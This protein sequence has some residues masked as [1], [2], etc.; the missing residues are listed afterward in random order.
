MDLEV[1]REK[2][3]LDNIFALAQKLPY[4][5]EILSH[6]AKYLC[7]LVSGFIEN[8]FR[9]M[10]INYISNKS[11]KNVAK[12]ATKYIEGI[13]NLNEPKIRDLL[14]KFNNDWCIFLEENISTEEKDAFDT[15]VINRHHISH[16]RH[17]A[18][19]LSRVKNN[20]DK[21]IRVIELVYNECISK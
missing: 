3:R 15:I 4:E 18:I 6:W 9:I 13:T 11:H 7:V 12:Y 2:Q 17:T 8:S 5:E 10:L 20:Y 16:G 19:T 21:I 14:G 1:L